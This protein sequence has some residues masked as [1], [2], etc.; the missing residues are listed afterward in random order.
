V[1]VVVCKTGIVQINGCFGGGSTIRRARGHRST[2]SPSLNTLLVHLALRSLEASVSV[3][4]PF[5][6]K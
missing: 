4:R 1:D 2:F 3:C 6:F 5:A